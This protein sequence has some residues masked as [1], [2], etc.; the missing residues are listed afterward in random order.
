MKVALVTGF[1]GQDGTLLTD[2]LLKKGY[3]VIGLVRR[4]STEPPRRVRGSFDFHWYLTMNQLVLHPG[5]LSSVVSLIDV[6]TKYNV[7]EIYNLAAQSHVK[8]SFEM[9]D[10]TTMVDYVG[11]MNL[12]TAMDVTKCQAKL[13]QASSSE[14]FGTDV[15]GAITEQTPF[16]PNSP[17]AIAKTAAHYYARSLRAQ[18][19]FV[20]AGILFNHESEV[21]GGDFVTQKIA[22]AAVTDELLEL[23]NVTSRRDWG[24]AQDYV[25]AMYDMMQNDV[26]REFVIGTG[27]DHSV[28]EFLETAYTYAGKTLVWDEGLGYVG[29]RLA[30]RTNSR[31][32]T[33]PLDVSRLLADPSRA[34]AELGWEPEIG[35][36]E[37]VHKMVDAQKESHAYDH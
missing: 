11:L 37:L 20:C 32:F 13:Y 9:P 31:A 17:Y 16:N 21:R 15:K 12:V 27:E 10:Y 28:K 24:H 33:R 19:R 30:V 26:P 7:D 35:F 25:R 5:D 3:Q 1:T 8:T 6:L 23:G 18:G 36:T 2:L 34:K 29:E 14:M 4:V 22:R